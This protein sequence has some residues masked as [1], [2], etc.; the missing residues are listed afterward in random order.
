MSN[1]VK[2]YRGG[3]LVNGV[4]NFAAAF[5]FL[6]E[7]GWSSDESVEVGINGAAFCALHDA[8]HERNHGVEAA[9]KTDLGKQ[10]EQLQKE[11]QAEGDPETLRAKLNELDALQEQIDTVGGEHVKTR[12]ATLEE[13]VQAIEES[14]G[15]ESPVVPID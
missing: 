8:E 5:G 10:K 13:R 4:A 3:E 11:I 9:G 14:L 15:V 12:P 6:V 2:I 7:A 1:P